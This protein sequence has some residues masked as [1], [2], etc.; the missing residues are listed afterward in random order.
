M[1]DKL[2]VLL[3]CL[4][5]RTLQSDFVQLFGLSIGLNIQLMGFYILASKAALLDAIRSFLLVVEAIFANQAITAFTF[6]R[7]LDDSLA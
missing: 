3:A 2:N 6:L 7:I 4:A 1:A 5:T